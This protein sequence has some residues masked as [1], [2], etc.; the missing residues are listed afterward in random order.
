MK[1][2]TS[3]VFTLMVDNEFGVLT[4]IT[5]LIRRAGWNIR[6]L[7]VAETAVPEISRLTI[8]LECRHH[9]FETV[10]ERLGRQSC[11]REIAV[12]EPDN[13][14]A[15]ELAILRV[16]NEDEMSMESLVEQY[17]AQIIEQSEDGRFL[18]SLCCDAGELDR[19]LP[20][21]RR[22]GLVEIARTGTIAMQRNLD[23][24]EE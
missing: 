11:V 13:Q 12:Y 19:W 10:L 24:E 3:H 17:G 2:Y 4:R 23:R 20:D 5:A 14:V 22:L 18:C 8:C 9:S 1:G 21:L 6:S 7:A 15:R 16:E